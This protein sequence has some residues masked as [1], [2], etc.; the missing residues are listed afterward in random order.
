MA[1]QNAAWKITVHCTAK[2]S[3]PTV[4]AAAQDLTS[5]NDMNVGPQQQKL[6]SI[7]K[8]VSRI[9]GVARVRGQ[10]GVRVGIGLGLELQSQI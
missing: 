10:V 5:W 9:R 6:I 8:L 7:R 3:S 1:Q 4:A 2:H